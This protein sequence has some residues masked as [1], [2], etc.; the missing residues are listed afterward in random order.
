[1]VITVKREDTGEYR[2]YDGNKRTVAYY[3]ALKKGSQVDF[4]FFLLSRDTGQLGS[5][6]ADLKPF[7]DRSQ[8]RLALRLAARTENEAS[9]PEARFYALTPPCAGLR[10]IV[11][12]TATVIVVARGSSG[13][14]SKVG[15][16]LAA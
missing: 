9:D 16:R 3:E 8:T 11:L 1:M 2:I 4:E 7:T 13:A 12:Q 14:S 6:L 15:K 10:T 5:E